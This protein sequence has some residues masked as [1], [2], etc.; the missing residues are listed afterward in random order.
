[1]DKNKN[2]YSILGVSQYAEEKLIKKHIDS[3]SRDFF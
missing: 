2:Y 1:M 3:S